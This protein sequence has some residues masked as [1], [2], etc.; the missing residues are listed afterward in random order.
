VGGVDEMIKFFKS[1][2]Y[3]DKLYFLN[4]TLSWLFI[5]VCIVITIFSGKLGI[6]DLSLVSVG[7]PA[8]F[9]E[10][11][12]HTGFIVWKAK[13]ENISKYGVQQ[14]EED[15]EVPIQAIGFQ[16]QNDPIEEETT[17]D[18]NVVHNNADVRSRDNSPLDGGDQ[19]S[20]HEFRER[21]LGKR[22]RFN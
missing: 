7:L 18:N 16:V 5:I 6:T 3:T 9:A 10:L 12:I 20:V 1:R 22:H 14:I 2:G 8:V 11:G 17:D 15:P 19:E 4:L 13:T 21:I